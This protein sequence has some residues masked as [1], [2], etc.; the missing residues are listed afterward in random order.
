MQSSD[1]H[2]FSSDDCISHETLSYEQP[3]SVSFATVTNASLADEHFEWKDHPYFHKT[4]VSKCLKVHA[5]TFALTS[6]RG[7]GGGSK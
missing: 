1:G 7:G 3:N 2:V 6:M 4:T 5:H